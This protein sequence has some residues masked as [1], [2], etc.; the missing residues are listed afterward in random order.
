MTSVAVVAHEKKSLGGGLPELRRLLAE[1]GFP[2]PIWYQVT[3]T[4]EA[5]T[6]AGMAIEQGADLIFLWGGDGTIQHCVEAVAGSG[7]AMAILPAGTANLLA[8][9]LGIPLD[10]SAAV[11]VGLH[12]TRR[13]IDVGVLNGERFAV[14]AG[15]GLD[16]EMMKNAKG[17]LKARFGRFAYVWT[18]IWATRMASRKVRIKVGGECWF[19]G[20]ASCVLIGNMGTLF[21]HLAVFPGARHDNGK[22]EVGV[23]TAEGVLQWA[24]IGARVVT[25]HADRSPLV[26][27]T[28]GEEIDVKFDTAVAYELDGS[29]RAA[30]RRLRVTVEPGALTVCVPETAGE[31]K[32]S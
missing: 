30:K 20:Q 6:F 9:N 11:D 13:A 23:V 7:V 10:L 27:L 28:Q 1:R 16:A 5:A 24:R 18:G 25:R 21:G 15:A 4:W 29:V 2:D 32:H 3:K 12:G 26:R 22:L 8:T 14:M 17:Q 31:P 19:K